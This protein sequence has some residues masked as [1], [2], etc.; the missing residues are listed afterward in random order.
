MQTRFLAQKEKAK[1]FLRQAIQS[2]RITSPY[3]THH[4]CNYAYADGVE[5]EEVYIIEPQSGD[6][7][8]LL[9]TPSSLK[10]SSSSSS[11][12]SLPPLRR[13]PFTVSQLVEMSPF[14]FTDRDTR[15][16]E[17]SSGY[18]D[19]RAFAVSHSG[20]KTPL[21]RTSTSGAAGRHILL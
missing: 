8:I 20:R 6:I 19:E 9:P 15:D 12:A 10:T 5:G 3:L 17:T 7:Y 11:S 16:I 18:R 2:N 14:S 13:F 21:H 1:G 4:I